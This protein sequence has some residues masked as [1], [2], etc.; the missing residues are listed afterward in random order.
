MSLLLFV[1]IAFGGATLALLVRSR[2]R[3]ADGV[4]AA[5][6]VGAAIAAAAIQPGDSAVVAGGQVTGTAF[7]RL[8]LL[9]GC[10]AGLGLVAVGAVTSGPRD[11]AAATL[12]GLGAAAIALG[13][14]DPILAVLAAGGGGFA[15][16]LVTLVPPRT[17]AGAVVAARH[18]QAIA[19]ALALS[20]VAAAWAA[21]APAALAAEPT[22]VGLTLVAMAVAVALRFGAIPFHLWAARLPDV[23]PELSLPLI[24]AWGPAALFVAALG[25]AGIAGEGAADF[26]LERGVI[27]AVGSATLLLGLAAAYLHDDLE[28]VVAYSIVADAGVALLAFSS[29]DAATRVEA[30]TWVLGFVVVKTA[31]AAW[32]AVI[33]T[34]FGARRLRDL[35]GWMTRSPLLAGAF[36]L[37]AL[38]TVGWPGLA[39]FD[40]RTTIVEAALGGPARAIVLLGMLGS[41]GY[42]GRIL[43]AGLGRRSPTV[44]AS[45]DPRPLWPTRGDEPLVRVLPRAWRANRAPIA[46]TLVALLAAGSI[47]V[48]MGGGGAREAAA[49]PAPTLPPS[50]SVAP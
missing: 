23:S 25:W 34:T 19:V 37:L 18:A 20:V 38:A 17:A 31:F 44:A 21:R 28:H 32:V 1:A 41:V 50:P 8:F 15:G 43:A 26:V 10:A 46:A 30:Q 42:L 29:A 6:L 3:L 39:Y 12:L 24:L 49:A 5:A 47:V 7:V 22:I 13:T 9:L 27:A 16:L 11:L 2:E 48:G 36:G 45:A 40:A 4:G 33:R 14:P 35:G